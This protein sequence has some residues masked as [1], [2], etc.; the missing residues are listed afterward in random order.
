MR[1]AIFGTG[2]VGGYFGGRLAQAGEDVTFIARG[3][4]LEAIQ[5]NGL[6]VESVQ[7]NFVIK[8]VKAIDDATRAGI[9]DIILVAVKSWDVPTAAE[10]M[11]PMV[12]RSTFIVP[13]ENGVDA[14][15][16]LA[17]ILGQEHVLGGM[18]RISATLGAPGVIRHIGLNPSIA[19]GEL[20]GR[21]SLRAEA[22]RK[23][24]TRIPTITVEIPEDIRIKIWEKFLFIASVS[25]VGAVTRQPLGVFRK[26]PETR[27]L[28]QASLEETAAIAKARGVAQSGDAVQSTLTFI[29]GL[30]PETTASMQRDIADGSPS[31][32]ESQNGAVVRM[33]RTLGIP[34]PAHEFI[35]ASLLPGEL[36]ARGKIT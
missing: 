16:Q 26:V 28:L 23:I 32:L 17:S 36:I 29:D 25:G 34:T 33:G 8:P 12:G 27:A 11:R 6:K 2:G 7:G 13:L 21:S 14:S 19:F 10:A 30:P 35:Y 9:M 15:D 24:F 18:C 31:E 3:A 5:K 4:H 22:L 20:D 1:I